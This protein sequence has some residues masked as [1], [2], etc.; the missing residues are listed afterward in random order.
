MIYLALLNAFIAV[1]MALWQRALM[2]AR[3]EDIP[4]TAQIFSGAVLAAGVVSMVGFAVANV[5][6]L[7]ALDKAFG[8]HLSPVLFTAWLL[9]M[10]AA[11]I[12]LIM[13]LNTFHTNRTAPVWIRVVPP[14]E[15]IFRVGSGATTVKLKPGSARALGIAGG[16]AGLTYV[17]YLVSNGDTEIALMVPFTPAAGPAINGSP[18]Q[19]RLSG[20]I[21]HGDPGKLHR[22]FAPFCE[23]Q[24]RD[25]AD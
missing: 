23:P 19:G 11:V 15:L 25:C 21:V 7:N 10:S 4:C 3:G 6:V 14:D 1:L 24:R 20:L 22:Y 2:H 5:L 8:R 16:M 17:Q 13:A 9:S 12:L 18:W